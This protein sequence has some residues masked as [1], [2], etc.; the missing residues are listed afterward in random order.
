VLGAGARVA[1]GLAGGPPACGA[2]EDVLAGVVVD[3]D[4]LA[5]VVAGG[6]APAGWA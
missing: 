5:D 4:V 2:E 3:E 6:A 1:D